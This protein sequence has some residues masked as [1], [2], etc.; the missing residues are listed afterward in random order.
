MTGATVGGWDSDPSA[1]AEHDWAYVAALSAVAAVLSLGMTGFEFGIYN[2]LFHLPV[3][4]RL[5]D[6]PQFAGDAYIQSLRFFAAGPFLLLRGVDRWVALPDLFLVLGWVSRALSFAGFLLC[7]RLIGVESRRDR[8][9]FAALLVVCNLVQGFSLAGDGGLFINYFTHSEMANGL[10]LVTMYLACRGRVGAAFAANG[11]VFFLNAFI[12]VWNAVP[13]LL[14]VLLLL[15]QRR[16]SLRQLVTQGATGLAV[17]LVLAAPVVANVVANPEYGL[18]TGYDYRVFLVEYWPFHFLFGPNLL[19]DKLALAT[20][21]ASGVLAFVAL[22]R[23]GR[24]S[25]S[26]FQA[27]L[28]GYV[29]VYLAGALAPYATSSAAVLNLHLL[30]SSTGIHLFAALGGVA[31]IV[32]WMGSADRVRA[33]VLAPGLGIALCTGKVL[34]IATPLVI[35]AGLMPW[36]ARMPP[37]RALARHKVAVLV[38]LAL[39]MWVWPRHAAQSAR[40]SRDFAAASKQWQAVGQ[41]AR[42]STPR[43]ATFLLPTSNI[44]EDWLR[45]DDTN[46]LAVGSEIFDYASHRR[47][48]V[49][50]RR[51]AAAMWSPSY[52]RVW[53]A[54]IGPVIQARTT[55]ERLALAADAGVGFL[56]DGCPARG[57]QADAGSPPVFRAGQLCVFR[58]GAEDGARGSLAAR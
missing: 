3:I 20:V 15:R 14:I 57:G 49:D 2:N 24:R 16:L 32:G 11:A 6:E 23:L 56:V 22:G 58:V 51:G 13:L 33:R 31:L 29:A 38:L 39:M 44:Q 40:A 37:V 25:A 43:D 53:H 54:R 55:A 45:H 21:L 10:C 7:G 34:A 12:A 35:L 8:A 30:R 48:W 9:V 52:Y 41:W 36:V 17:F 42:M 46:E 18:P 4:A 26:G 27:A 1:R 5:Y 19:A 47:V 50:F 28:W